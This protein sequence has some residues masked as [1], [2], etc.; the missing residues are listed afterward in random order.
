MSDE[1]L[2]YIKEAVDRIEA[3]QD[4]HGD[5]IVG[6]ERW[7][8]NADGKMTMLGIVCAGVGAVAASVVTYFRH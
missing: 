6:I 2:Q 5:R 8:S 3:K 4:K 1:T 7:Q